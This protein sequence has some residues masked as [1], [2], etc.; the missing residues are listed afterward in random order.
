MVFFFS[1]FFLSISQT[2]VPNPPNSPNHQPNRPIHQPNPTHQPNPSNP[3]HQTHQ[4][5][6]NPT[7]PNP[8]PPNPTHPGLDACLVGV[9]LDVGTSN[10]SGTRMGPRQIRTESVLLR[11]NN[12]ATGAMPFESLNVAD[13]GDVPMNIYK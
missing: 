10:R 3:T 9:P 12:Q 5:P 13:V 1:P 8:N 6:S 4:T 2:L 11:P 7:H